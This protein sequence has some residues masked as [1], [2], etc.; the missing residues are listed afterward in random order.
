L[1]ARDEALSALKQQL[2]GR[3]FSSATVLEVRDGGSA[4]FLLG[5]RSGRRLRPHTVVLPA[6]EA[7]LGFDYMLDEPL[8]TD[9]VDLWA[10]RV[11]VWLMVELDTG[12]LRRGRRVTLD[13]GT[14][15]VDPIGVRSHEPNP[16]WVSS[17]PLTLF[18]LPR[19]RGPMAWWFVL[20]RVFRR[21]GVRVVTVEDGDA[22]EP[23]PAPGGHLLDAGLDA[24]PGRAAYGDGRLIEWLQLSSGGRA[25]R[26]VGQLVVSWRDESEGIAQLEH[27]EYLSSAPA[28]AIEELMLTGVH[29]AADAGARWIERQLDSDDQA[30]PDLP[31][32]TVDGLTRL[33]ANDVP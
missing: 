24:R 21:G 33:D 14:E 8:G 19:I 18:P 30:V 4:G 29:A 5:V 15:A 9:D 6:D 31:W 10:D 13:D 26:W 1:V 2:T 25:S 16:D 3:E 7:S 22:A 17:V 32:E 11:A 23:D 20:R 27:L 28:D 12:V